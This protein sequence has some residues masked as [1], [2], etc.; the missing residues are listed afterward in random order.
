MLEE[1][2]RNKKARMDAQENEK[3]QDIAAQEAY[4]K[5]LDKQENDRNREFT[6]REKRA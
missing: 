6:M 5:M 3:Q 4:A 1:N 2:E